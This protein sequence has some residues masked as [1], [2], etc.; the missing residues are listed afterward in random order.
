M[1][2]SLESNSHL[3]SGSSQPP[4]TTQGLFSTLLQSV[5]QVAGIPGVA[6][7]AA[8]AVAAVASAVHSGS[9]ASAASAG[10][11]SGL[12]GPAS[13]AAS[14]TPA[15]NV[16][17]FLHSL[18]AA[19]KADGPGMSGAAASVPPATPSAGNGAAAGHYQG[20]LA[21]SLQSLIQQVDSGA[22]TPA[23]AHLNASFDTLRQ[24]AD[25]TAAASASNPT[26]SLTNFLHHLLQTVQTGAAQSLSPVGGN[27]NASV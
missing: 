21:A 11:G 5:Q 27:V 22:A 23:T 14:V 15:Q 19:L 17:S 18:F 25:G 8:S 6:S 7:L 9:A 16:Q 12:P 13:T 26:A 2:A 20:G 10:A 24:G 3:A 4:T 1:D